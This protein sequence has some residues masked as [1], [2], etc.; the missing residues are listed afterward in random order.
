M[1]R[2]LRDWRVWALTLT[3]QGPGARAIVRYAPRPAVVLPL[4]ILSSIAAYAVCLHRPLPSWLRRA[5]SRVEGIAAVLCLTAAIGVVAYPKV[6]ARRVHGLGSDE[7]DALIQT[8]ERLV[9]FQRPLY[10]PTYLGNAPSVGPGWALLMSPLAVTGMYP[11]LTPLAM[12]V[13]I[14]TV[15]RSGG[16]EAG[17]ALALAL[18]L[19]SPAF[20][21]LFAAGS[22]LFAIGV[23]FVVLTRLAWSGWKAASKKSI[24][25][26]A[27]VCAAA[28][29]RASFAWVTAC[30]SLFMWRKGRPGAALAAGVT[31]ATVAAE[32]WFWLPRSE[33]TP[34][35]LISKL[36]GL[37]GIGGSVMAVAA[38]VASVAWASLHLGDSIES[39][40]LGLWVTLV[41]PL[42]IVSLGVLAAL[43]WQIAEWQAA[44]Y[45]EVAVPALVAYVAATARRRDAP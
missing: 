35:S 39:W 2:A 34:L 44:G 22:D 16:G 41:V 7:D 42:A 23:L 24:A 27:L 33:Q 37:L 5:G 13:L 21:E 17:T 43:G 28:S 3:I 4:V 9:T 8:A 6:D 36:S 45:V 32:A 11:L 10:I 40:W 19:A 1:L 25:A 38:A 18:P 26:A 29:A 31:A 12:A 30:V 20:W 15:R 14:S